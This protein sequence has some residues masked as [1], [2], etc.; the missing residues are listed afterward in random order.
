MGVGSGKSTLLRCRERVV[1]IDSGSIL[2]RARVYDPKLDNSLARKVGM[3][4]AIQSFRTRRARQL[5]EGPVH[6]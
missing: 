2:S 6:V 4:P 5:H 1:P 3:V